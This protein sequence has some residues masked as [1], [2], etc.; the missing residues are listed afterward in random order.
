[1]KY[2]VLGAFSSA[3]L[4]YGIALTY[5]ATGS[6]NLST[7]NAFLAKNVLESTGLLFAGFALML[8]GL[9]F[10]IAAVPF[11]GHRVRRVLGPVHVPAAA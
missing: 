5:G 2:F 10:K 11:H 9:G 3:F 8:V 6:T 7:I 4:L 1:M